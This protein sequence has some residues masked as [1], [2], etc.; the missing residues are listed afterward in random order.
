MGRYITWGEVTGR[1]QDAAKK[2]GDTPMGSYWLARAEDEIDGYLASR[3]TTPFSPTPG[4]VADLC[5]D[6]TYYKMIIQQEGAKPIWEYID[7]RLK[8]IVNGTMVLT[9]SG[10]ALAQ[11]TAAWSE[12]EGH[13]TSFGPDDYLNYN[14]S[15]QWV[16]DV[17]DEREL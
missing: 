14:I 2:A 7:Y 11:G 8:A 13:H 6:L 12:H 15:S 1:Y 10:T 16:G 5:V 17:Q 4:V 9:S 3:Y